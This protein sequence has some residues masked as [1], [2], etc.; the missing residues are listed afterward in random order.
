[1][2]FDKF[3]GFVAIGQTIYFRPLTGRDVEAFT[4]PADQDAHVVADALNKSSNGI[5]TLVAAQSQYHF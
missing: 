1:M 2:Q 3:V 5:L 4:V